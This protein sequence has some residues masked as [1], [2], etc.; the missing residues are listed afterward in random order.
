MRP[1]TATE[2][3]IWLQLV[4]N[5]DGMLLEEVKQYSIHAFVLDEYTTDGPGYQG[6]I[7]LIIWP[8][9]NT[10]MTIFERSKEL[11]WQIAYDTVQAQE[12]DPRGSFE[13]VVDSLQRHFE[14]DE[15][16]AEL[17]AR[18]EPSDDWVVELMDTGSVTVS[19]AGRTFELT[20]HVKEI[21]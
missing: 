9:S 12:G 8:G 6:P 14:T 21:V 5:R 1:A 11:R 18:S 10:W 15:N 13:A 20:L 3:E 19:A 7:G 2:K 17:I 16:L 4:A